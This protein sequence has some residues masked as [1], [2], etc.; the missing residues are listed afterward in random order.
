MNDKPKLVLIQDGNQV[1]G[2]LSDGRAEMAALT[3]AAAD[4]AKV[5]A[6][7]RTDYA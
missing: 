1:K 6:S 4:L 2:K 5:E 7:G 3:D